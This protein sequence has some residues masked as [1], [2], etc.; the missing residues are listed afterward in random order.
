MNDGKEWEAMKIDSWLFPFL[1]EL[2]IENIRRI[3]NQEVG[4]SVYRNAIMEERCMCVYS[5]PNLGV[6]I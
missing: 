4:T 3:L 6:Y 5:A 2:T 1:F